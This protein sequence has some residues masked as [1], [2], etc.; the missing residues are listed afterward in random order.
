MTVADYLCGVKRI[1]YQLSIIVEGKQL[2]IEN[3]CQRLTD[4]QGSSQI[5]FSSLSIPAATKVDKIGRD[6]AVI[7]YD[8]TR[9]VIWPKEER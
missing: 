6:Y 7:N 8:K 4:I 3:S 9:L 5:R 1:Y 2:L